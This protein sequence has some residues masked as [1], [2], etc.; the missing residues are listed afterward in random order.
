MLEEEAKTRNSRQPDLQD[1][2]NC[3][4]VNCQRNRKGLCATAQ[5]VHEAT[6]YNYKSVSPLLCI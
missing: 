2:C 4:A 3:S 1:L 6:S 5:L